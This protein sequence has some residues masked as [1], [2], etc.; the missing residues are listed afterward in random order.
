MKNKILAGVVVVLL[1]SCTY[2]KDGQFVKDADGKVY[3]LEQSAG[4]ESYRLREVDTIPL[5]KIL[6]SNQ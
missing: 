4:N 3:R 1:A 5:K 2:R 6:N